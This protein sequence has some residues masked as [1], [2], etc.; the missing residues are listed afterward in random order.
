MRASVIVPAY[1][2]EPTIT[3]VVAGLVDLWPEPGA[4]LVIDDGSTDQTASRA[5]EAGA[6]VLQH[7]ANR[8][9]GEALRTGLREAAARGYDVAISVDADG[10]HPPHEAWRLHEA[11]DDAAAIVIGV[12]DLLRA[13]APRNS[14]LSNAFSNWVLSAFTQRKLDDTQCGLRRYP[15]AATLALGAK[16]PGYDYEA[17][18]LIRGVA[19]NMRIVH[20][21]IDVFYPPPE[22]RISHF[23][24]V[25]DPARIVVRVVGTV[26]EEQ[27]RKRGRRASPGA[28]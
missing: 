13:G 7:D 22:E 6:T 10:Q 19:A 26:I 27:W 1:Q 11:C 12:R 28:Q 17:E 23:D 21:A 14:Q 9:K 8:G 4:V 5:R 16:A 20:H 15:I 3:S 25:R 24:N 18:V 2:A